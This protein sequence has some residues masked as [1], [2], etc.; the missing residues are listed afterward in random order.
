MNGLVSGLNGALSSTGLRTG[1]AVRF[2]QDWLEDKAGL[3]RNFS[4]YTPAATWSSNERRLA[5]HEARFVLIEASTPKKTQSLRGRA[6]ERG[7]GTGEEGHQSSIT[8]STS[9]AILSRVRSPEFEMYGS[10]SGA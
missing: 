3:T 1:A 9:L 5:E 4:E 6:A 10:A 2:A 8:I 7:Y